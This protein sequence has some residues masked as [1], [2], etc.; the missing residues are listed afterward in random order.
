MMTGPGQTAHERLTALARWRRRDTTVSGPM[1][2]A[3]RERLHREVSRQSVA[4]SG[5]QE[6]VPIPAVVAWWR[7][8]RALAGWVG[9]GLGAVGVL[10]VMSRLGQ[11]GSPRNRPLGG[12]LE[13]SVFRPEAETVGAPSRV[14]T[15]PLSAPL[16]LDAPISAPIA[17]APAL[18]DVEAGTR[19]RPA[20]RADSS[21][22]K[23]MRNLDGVVRLRRRYLAAGDSN[24]A[25][26]AV[27]MLRGFEV[28]RLSDRVEFRDDDGSIYLGRVE[29]RLV[30]KEGGERGWAFEGRGTN[31]ASGKVVWITGLFGPVLEPQDSRVERFMEMP[32]AGTAV[33]GE[34]QVVEIRAEPG[35]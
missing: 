4:A 15:A 22:A 6:P 29:D 17:A 32:F 30:A 8:W 19:V 28:V 14:G 13:N 21:A 2:T 20:I 10:V 11:D 1:P 34:T 18:V 25:P 33:V 9:I 31:V 3:M 24:A 12:D 23:Q 7:R 35:H 5:F 16:S 26:A 27:V